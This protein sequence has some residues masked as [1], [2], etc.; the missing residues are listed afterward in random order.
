MGIINSLGL[1]P[2]KASMGIINSH[3]SLQGEGGPVRARGGPQGL[4]F[5][6]NLQG[7]G[8]GGATKGVG[9]VKGVGAGGRSQDVPNTEPQNVFRNAFRTRRLAIWCDLGYW[10]AQWLVGLFHAHVPCTCACP[11]GRTF[12]I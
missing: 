5:F 9:G 3:E 11:S 7:P 2:S 8:G 10:E 12:E 4:N 6:E 1:Y